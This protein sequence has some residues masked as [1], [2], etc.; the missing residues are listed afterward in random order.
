MEQQTKIDVAIREIKFKI[1]MAER[2]Y[3]CAVT[4]MNALR[5]ILNAL[6]RIQGNE[7]LK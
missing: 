6:E 4:K 2:E 7:K 1:E 3:E 5:D